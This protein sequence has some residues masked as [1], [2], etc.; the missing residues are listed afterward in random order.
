MNLKKWAMAAA[1]LCT[2]V[3]QA[4][5]YSLY[6]S[7]GKLLTETSVAPVDLSLPLGEALNERFG[8]DVT[9]VVSDHAVFCGK[10]EVVPVGRRSLADA[11]RAEVAQATVLKKAQVAAAGAATQLR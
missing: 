8:P 9:M 6:W 2:G 4:T 5:C 1:M 3:A 11:V 10:E 7:D